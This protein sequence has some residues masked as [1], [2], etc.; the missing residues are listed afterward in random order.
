MLS[1]AN[2]ASTSVDSERVSI[3]SVPP[4]MVKQLRVEMPRPVD[5]GVLDVDIAAVLCVT[6]QKEGVLGGAY[7]AECAGGGGIEALAVDG[8]IVYSA[9]EGGFMDG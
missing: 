7:V 6:V 4:L 9:T 8:E 1:P 5:L 3:V 2:T